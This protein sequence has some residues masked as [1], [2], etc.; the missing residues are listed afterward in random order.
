MVRAGAE[1]D[2]EERA[3]NEDRSY[4]GWPGTPD[5][6][7][8]T[9]KSD[10]SKILKDSY[11]SDITRS[12]RANWTGQLWRF[13]T[14]IEI[15]DFIVM[16]LKLEPGQV[17]IGRV[18]GNYEFDEEEQ[19]GFRH[20]REVDWGTEKYDRDEFCDDIRGTLG[21]FLTV[22]E[23][24]QPHVITRLE[25]MIDT[26]VDPGYD[27]S[28][29][30]EDPVALLSTLVDS[31]E[32]DV[33]KISIRDIL[34]YWGYYRRNAR[35]VEEITSALVDGGLFVKP[36]ISDGAIDSVV[37]IT[38]IENRGGEQ[39]APEERPDDVEQADMSTILTLEG[40]VKYVIGTMPSAQ[41]EVTV[42]TTDE[43]LAQAVTKMVINDYSQLPVVDDENHLLGAITWPQ[44]SL[45]L[46]A[47][48]PKT[49]GEV[50]QTAPSVTSQDELLSKIDT[51]HYEGFVVVCD[52][53]N[54]VTGIV[55]SSDLA[56]RFREDYGPIALLDEIER[57][58]RH[59]FEEKTT[60]D[61][62][63]RLGVR[64]GREGYSLGNYAK[65]MSIEDCWDIVG[66]PAL[67][68]KTVAD[69]MEEVRLIR[70]S[71]MHFSP[72]PL[73]KDQ[74]AKIEKAVRLFR[75]TIPITVMREV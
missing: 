14:Q 25:S 73:Q 32:G 69:L 63:R 26:G 50:C 57:R 46:I 48:T 47:G 58:L 66:W 12:A 18:I 22:C 2:R 37:A 75:R 6:S 67:D 21:S 8:A 74:V 33:L 36:S 27:E 17:A 28:D 64:V 29:D 44:I 7:E 65:A 34:G 5:F 45:G 31:S 53:E 42:T 1:G 55:T 49:V 19:D 10:I 43:E 59:R 20:S 40:G 38:P 62:M 9:T 60:I 41:C 70:N 11:G 61:E 51:I 56:S 3:F 39:E 13:V 71:L 23:I 15:G 72:D 16:P 68:R 35:I 4:A 30:E 54:R 24:A 52:R